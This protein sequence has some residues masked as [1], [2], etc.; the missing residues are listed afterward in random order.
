MSA[1][2][3]IAELEASVASL[4]HSLGL[5]ED[6]KAVQDLQH[7]YG[8]YM[9]N[10][11]FSEVTTLF[12]RDCEVRFMGGSFRGQAGARRMFEG[13]L[14]RN[15]TGGTNRPVRGFL[16]LHMMLQDVIHVA[17]DRQ[18]AK[19]RFRIFMQ[20][21]WHES[22]RPKREAP[23]GQLG[24]PLEMSQWWEAGL[25]ENSYVKE[26]GVWKIHVLEFR[27]TYHASFDKGWARS[28]VGFVPSYKETYPAD[29]I[30][31]D[32]IITPAWRSWPDMDVIPYHYPNPV[33]GAE[34][35]A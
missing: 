21:G 30:G 14:G 33:T 7:T 12:S 35:E 32:E 22:E 28:P 1:D 20:A 16:A 18:S 3:R 6:A 31:P 8:Y 10:L 9:D 27:M 2:N 11:L 19:G 34:I 13:G 4:S 26:D 25:Y 15:Y 23:V 24:M 17:E 29:P 5:L